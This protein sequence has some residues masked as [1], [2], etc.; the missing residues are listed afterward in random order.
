MSIESTYLGIS[1][2]KIDKVKFTQKSNFKNKMYTY[3]K[4]LKI[5]SDSI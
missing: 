5:L 2:K 1:T 3:D 4:Y